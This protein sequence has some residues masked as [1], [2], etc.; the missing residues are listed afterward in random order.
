MPAHLA[1]EMRISQICMTLE[2]LGQLRAPQPRQTAREPPQPPPWRTARRVP[3]GACRR[4]V[5]ARMD[6]EGLLPRGTEAGSTQRA[7][8]GGDVELGDWPG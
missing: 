2:Q 6:A 3:P 1:A 8:E 5:R 7:H 4:V